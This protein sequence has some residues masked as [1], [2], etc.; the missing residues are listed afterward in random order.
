MTCHT[1]YSERW[2]PNSYNGSIVVLCMFSFPKMDKAHEQGSHC[3][4]L[5]DAV[6]GLNAKSLSFDDIKHPAAAF[7][8]RRSCL[9]KSQMID[10]SCLLTQRCL[11]CGRVV[12]MTN[13]TRLKWLSGRCSTSGSEVYC[14]CWIGWWLIYPSF[15]L[16]HWDIKRIIS[17]S[18]A[19]EVS[20][21]SCKFYSQ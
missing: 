13:V 5:D 11:W 6:T 9:N 1:F 16:T 10:L 3:T 15:S 8:I 12:V 14:W 17:F 18:V 4:A 7:F 2:G 21:P 20:Y 19:L